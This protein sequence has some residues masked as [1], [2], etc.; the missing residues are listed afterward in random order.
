MP[1]AG[2]A[3]R[4]AADL[5]GHVHHALGVFKSG[6]TLRVVVDD[7]RRKADHAFDRQAQ[8]GDALAQVRQRAAI[9]DIGIEFGDPRFDA[10]ESGPSGDLQLLDQRE[11][12][13][14]NRAGVEAIAKRFACGAFGLG[15]GR[16]LREQAR[17]PR[18]R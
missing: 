10:T 5:G 8:V 15:R 1:E 6:G 13:S 14:A 4:L 3:M 9:F 7:P 18:P 2:A 12:L 16:R 11:L 17:R